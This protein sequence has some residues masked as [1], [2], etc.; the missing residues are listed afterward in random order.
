MLQK[1]REI[2]T[3]DL[4]SLKSK[5]SFGQNLAIMFSG[6]MVVVAS[7][8]FLTPIVTRIFD[9]A[10]YGVFSI[11]NILVLNLSAIATLSLNQ[12]LVL[13]ETKKEFVTLFRYALYTSFGFFLLFLLL[14]LILDDFLIRRFT[15]EKMGFLF[16]LIPFGVLLQSIIYLLTSANVRYKEFKINAQTRSSVGVG[17]RAFHIVFGLATNGVSYGL[18]V[19]ELVGKL[20]HFT[21]LARQHFKKRSLSIQGYSPN[22]A[23]LKQVAI[24]YRQ[25]PLYV[26]PGNYLNLLAGQL[27]AMFFLKYD[28]GVIGAYSLSISLLSI[29]IQTIGNS[30]YS[31]FLQKAAEIKSHN[32]SQL[33]GLFHKLFVRL[34]AISLIG[35]GSIIFLAPTV[36]P[37]ALGEDWQ[38]SGEIASILAIY[39]APYMIFS[40]LSSLFTVLNMERSRL[41]ISLVTLAGRFGILIFLIDK[42]EPLQLLHILSFYNLGVYLFYIFYLIVRARLASLR[43]AVSAM[44][45]IGAI[46]AIFVF[47]KQLL[48]MEL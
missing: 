46:I 31:V 7:Q 44:L 33:S 35:Y 29:P 14:T 11:F 17:T 19:G 5:G 45:S 32:I 8:L 1:L 12:S 38:L 22:L 2:I 10:D 21:I 37:I 27:P 28:F 47:A 48:G 39:F 13:P 18:I 43:F 26:T 30:I 25:F 15:L 34:A 20:S 4:R 6:S 41:I 42:L 3:S 36:F 24:K 23:S 16:Y 9:A 40:P